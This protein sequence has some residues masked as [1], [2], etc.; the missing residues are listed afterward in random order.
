MSLIEKNR[1]SA[2]LSGARKIASRK[3][4]S[5]SSIK[6]DILSEYTIDFSSNNEDSTSK[7]DINGGVEDGSKKIIHTK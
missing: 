7:P 1:D 5:F 4:G 6:I 2:G 3:L